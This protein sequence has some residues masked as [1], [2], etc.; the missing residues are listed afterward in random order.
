MA[1]SSS[2][3]TR[4]R[5]GLAGVSASTSVVLPGMHR[6]GERTRLGAVDEGD[7]DAEAGA[8]R[9]EQQLGAGVE[10]A[11]GDDVVAGRAQPEHHRGDRPHARGEGPGRLGPLELGDGVLEAGHGGVAV[12]AVEAVGA[13]RGGHA[14]ALVDGRRHER[15]GGPQDRRQRGAV[16]G[17]A[18]ADGDGLGVEAGASRG[19]RRRGSSVAGFSIWLEERRAGRADLVGARSGRRRGRAGCR[20]RRRWPR[21][22]PALRAVAD[23]LLLV[24]RVEG[25][26]VDAHASGTG[27]VMRPARRRRRRGRGRG[28]AGPWPWLSSR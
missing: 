16:V 20:S 25:V 15:G 14:A 6:G 18:G 19:S 28:R 27:A 12:A 13:D 7:V 9:L 22:P 23:Q 26:G 2:R 5:R 11:L 10:L 3:S 17:P 1:P 8:R 21:V 24:R 4:S